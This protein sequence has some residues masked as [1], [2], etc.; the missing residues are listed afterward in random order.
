ML[1]NEFQNPPGTFNL[2]QLHTAEMS[3]SFLDEE[4]F[5]WCC[6]L[7]LQQSEQLRDGWSW[8][9]VQ[10]SE[11]GFLRKTMVRSVPADWMAP[12]RGSRLFSLETQE[13]ETEQPGSLRED[14][15][16]E[17][18]CTVKDGS[19]LQLQYEYHILYSC[20]YAVPVLYFRASTLEGRSLTLEE[21]W[22]SIH[23][24]FRVHLQSCPLNAVSQ[25]EHPLL[26]QPFFFLHPCRTEEFMRP[27]VEA[28]QNHSRPV[29]YVLSWLSA[30]GPVVGLDLPLQYS[31]QLHPAASPSSSSMEAD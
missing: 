8:E 20:S 27:V 31:T 1:I 7:L 18:V 26:G 11:E 24:S 13:Q 17:D 2:P 16:D 15:E 12:Q 5:R 10:G 28:A 19:S 25:Q 21:V 30:V 6:R 29:N 23:P 14:E 3:C 9:A 4:R 22:S